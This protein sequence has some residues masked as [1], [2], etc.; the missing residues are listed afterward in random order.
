MSRRPFLAAAGDYID[1]IKSV[2]SPRRA[3]ISKAE[4]AAYWG[5]SAAQETRKDSGISLMD[6]AMADSVDRAS[7]NVL[8]AR[9]RNLERNS[10]TAGGID[11]AFT[12]NVIGIGF[13]MQAQ[14]PSD[15]FNNRIE[16]L[17]DEWCHHENCDWTKQQS[18][19]DLIELILRRLLYDGGILATFPLDP[20]REIPLTIQL[21][22]VDELDDSLV[23]AENGNIIVNGVEMTDTAVPVAYWLTQT[24]PDGYTPLP[25]LRY[26]ADDVIFLWKRTRVSQ[27]REVTPFHAA[28]SP[29]QDLKDYNDAISFQQKTAAC[30]SVYIETDNTINAPGRAINTND[31]RRIEHIEGGSVKYLN[32]GEHAKFLLPTGQANEADNH[33]ATQQ[34]GIA[35]VFGLSLESTSRN[36]E[37]VN[38]S[39]ARQNLVIDTV[40]YDRM[41]NYLKEYFLRPLYKRFVQ[42]CYLKG[43][44][45]G[46]GFE[47][48]NKK[49]YEAKWLTS[50]VGWID[51]LKEAQADTILLA[52]GGVSFQDYVAKHGQDWRER[53]DEMAEVQAY[54]KEK[55]VNLSFSMEDSNINSDNGKEDNN[56]EENQNQN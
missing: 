41:K 46:T 21:H 27:F 6:N 5:Y 53:I 17:W 3:A 15:T 24:T 33:I 45:K 8:R 20:K 11:K 43:L 50:S 39:S 49:F 55:G 2:F 28:I 51:P 9:A 37:R 1:D 56:G 25:P 44:L 36:V 54:A 7:R 26:S 18:L 14:S 31:N 38:Y 4:R 52:N 23:N 42:I 40:T 22:E 32:N 13:N 30:T 12:N 29:A 35:S 10:I 19:D 48:G 47:L 34:R 16:E